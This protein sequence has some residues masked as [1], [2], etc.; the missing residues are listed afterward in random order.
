MKFLEIFRIFG[1]C[2]NL[3]DCSC[4]TDWQKLRLLQWILRMDVFYVTHI[5]HTSSPLCTWI[6]LTGVQG[7]FLHLA[8]VAS[9]TVVFISVEDCCAS[10]VKLW[11]PK[12]VVLFI[13][14]LSI[15]LT[16]FIWSILFE[17]NWIT[18]FHVNKKTHAVSLD[19]IT[20]YMS[21]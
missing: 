5:A 7:N 20:K 1:A 6:P 3:I 14:Y 10:S 17:L 8:L 15:T 21:N 18:L 4:E 11:V 12:K 13:V 16:L 9:L 2:G 19:Y